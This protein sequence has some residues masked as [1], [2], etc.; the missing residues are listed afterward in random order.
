L[1]PVSYLTQ[2]PEHADG[3]HVDSLLPKA[4]LMILAGTETTA[5]ALSGVIYY[6]LANPRVLHRAVHED[7]EAFQNAADIN[8]ESTQDLEYLKP[9]MN[10]SQRMYPS[11]PGIFPRRVPR[12]GATICGQHVPG[13]TIVGIPHFAAFRSNNNFSNPD[14]Y[15]PERWLG[16]ESLDKRNAFHPFSFGPRGCIGKEYVKNAPLSCD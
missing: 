6:L 3:I 16:E 14:K 1:N 7:R 13:N 8:I 9:C 2:R 11:T 12:E 4:F 10:E 15:I 5:T